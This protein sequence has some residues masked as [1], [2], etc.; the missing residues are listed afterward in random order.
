MSFSYDRTIPAGSLVVVSGANGFIA[1]HVVDQLLL[2][3][4][5]V[6]GTCRKLSRSEWLIDFFNKKYGDGSFELS[7][8]PD[9]GAPH[10]FDDVVKGAAGFIHV[11]T[12]VMQS[13][14]PNKAVPTVVN[15]II[16]TLEAAL[17]EAGLKRIVMTSSSTAATSPKPNVEFSIDEETWNKED[18][19]AAW[20]PPPYEGH[21][22]VL[23]VYAASK[24][25]SE[26][27]AWKWMKEHKPHFVLNAILPNANMGVVLSPENQ[28]SPSTVGWLKALWNGFEGHED[29]KENPPQYYINVQDNARVHV[30]ALLSP[31]VNGERLYTF[32]HPFNWN[33][34]LAIY[35]KVY[36][37]HQF[38]D[39]IPNL[40]R[41]LSKVANGRAEELLK[42][43][44]VKGWASLE[45]SVIAA[46]ES[47][48]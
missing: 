27:A 39:D 47:W 38:I 21:D 1:S 8:V 17:K 34:I 29:L 32:A 44:G 3:G 5:K 45:E 40:G 6:R 23:A 9:M 15:G 12:P 46:A 2:A 4:Y 10:A 11:A 30:A 35:R 13:P 28:G 16:N 20:K 37:E 22:R 26:Q 33:D 14:D 31:D 25:Q 41:D 36:P 24:T 19:E 43:F 7:E 48:A 42:R 18:I